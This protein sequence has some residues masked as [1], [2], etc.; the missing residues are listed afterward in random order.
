MSLVKWMD[1]T[2]YPAHGE[3]WDDRILRERILES[4]DDDHDL[5]DLGAGAGRVAEMNFKG[6]AAS[7]CG[8]DVD[9][10]VMANPHLDEGRIGRGEVIPY[11]DEC[12]D[13]VVADNVLEHLERPREVFRE[14]ARVLRP[15]GRFIAKTPNKRHYMP[16]IARLTSTRF[17][18]FVNRL[19]GRDEADTFPTRYLAN[20]PA[21][22]RR[23]AE[24]AGLTV[25][26]VELIEGRP[27][28]LRWNALT[29]SVGTLY[30]RA[31]NL[32]PFLARWRVLMVVELEKPARPARNRRAA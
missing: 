9:E 19:R 12:F 30:E 8:I 2:L 25:K 14:V 27:E 6:L 7:V 32:L 5:L 26:R 21:D 16:T 23:W 3:R 24:G 11:A 31:V 18:Q 22:V 10:R 1:R 28:Y 29:Y 4:I 20:T 17:H 15:G 13:V